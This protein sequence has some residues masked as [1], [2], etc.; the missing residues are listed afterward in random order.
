MSEWALR[1]AGS[2]YVTLGS[3]PTLSNGTSIP[4]TTAHVKTGYIDLGNAPFDCAAL[5]VTFSQCSTASA[6]LTDIALGEAGSERIVAENLWWSSVTGV[7][8]RGAPYLLPIHIQNRARISARTQAATLNATGRIMV[9]CI[10]A[11]LPEGASLGR[12]VTRGATVSTTMGTTIAPGATAHTDSSW[13][14]FGN[15]PFN[16]TGLIIA[17]GTDNLATTSRGSTTMLMDLGIGESGS[18]RLVL[19]DYFLSGISTDDNVHPQVSQL[20]PVRI[21]N[22]ARIAVRGRGGASVAAD[23]AFGIV[24][25]LF[26]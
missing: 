4:G 12:M 1:G 8:F 24:L 16:V 17:A 2:R 25:Y 5:L 13:V 9:H 18:E 21:P 3:N 7:T 20:L 10:A 15:A 23:N 11:G 22:R 26:G 19:E 14:N 6:H